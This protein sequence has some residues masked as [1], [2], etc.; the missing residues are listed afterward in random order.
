[1]RLKSDLV[2]LCLAALDGR[3]DRVSADWDERVALGLVVAA[4][5]VGWLA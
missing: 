5:L 1:M 4:V 2:A 3:L